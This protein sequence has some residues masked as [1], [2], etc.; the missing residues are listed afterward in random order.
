MEVSTHRFKDAP[1]PPEHSSQHRATLQVKAGGF[2]V[3]AFAASNRGMLEDFYK[4]EQKVLGEGSY[5]SVRKCR[6]KDTNQTCAVKT[7]SKSQVKNE[8]QFKEEMAIMRLLDHPNIVRLYETFEDM[9]NTYLVLELCSGGELFDRIF[10]DGK[11]T[12]QVAAHCVQ[13]MLRALNY[14]HQNWIM[15]RDVKPENWLLATDEAIRKTDLK[16]I[17]FGLSKRF[18]PGELSSTKTGTPYYV[19]PE[20]LEGQYAEK[21]DVWS[22]GVIMYMM[23]CGSPPFQGN[24]IKAVLASVMAAQ[25]RFDQKEWK[26]VSTEAKTVLR[27]LLTRDPERRLSAAE[28]VQCEWIQ[29]MLGNTDVKVAITQQVR[30]NLRT[31]SLMNKLKKASLNVVATQ[32]NDSAIRDLKSWFMSMDDN[33]DGS[34]SVSELRQGFLKAGVSIPEDLSRM[35]EQ[36]DTDGSGVID[37]SE[38][39]AATIERKKYIAEDVCWRAFKTF[40][41]DGSGSIDRQEL[42]RLLG[43]DDICDVMEVEVTE[44]EIDDIMRE[45]DL[46]GDGKIDFEEFLQMMRRMPIQD[47]AKEKTHQRGQSLEQPAKIWDKCGGAQ[48]D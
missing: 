27:A 21:S 44:R 3:G 29:Q 43:I 20:V 45:V 15:H 28:A 23:L 13:Q 24:D 36:I 22:I 30:T 12:E 40:D 34:L 2:S 17:D 26:G 31:F 14:M 39:V 18:V 42:G 8:A 7:V 25:L 9:R 48:P 33:S 35:M 47:A 10:T 4:V 38:F 46:N 16:L 32:L 37:Y 19:S 41:V 1:L 11:F 6:A 5:G